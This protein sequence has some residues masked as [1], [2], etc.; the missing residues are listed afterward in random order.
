MQSHGK[1]NSK[2]EIIKQSGNLG[3][4]S[5]IWESVCFSYRISDRLETDLQATAEI[6]AL[7]QT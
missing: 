6:L 1:S 2:N 5:V 4:S 7:L 3:I